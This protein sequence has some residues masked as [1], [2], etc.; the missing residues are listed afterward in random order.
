MKNAHA[1]MAFSICDDVGTHPK[2]SQR[3]E[4]THDVSH[5]SL[6]RMQFPSNYRP[7]QHDAAA[8]LG[9]SQ[10][11]GPYERSAAFQQRPERVCVTVDFQLC[12][13]RCEALADRRRERRGLHRRPDT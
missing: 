9:R 8:H 5:V 1:N 2:C 11:V 3:R 4:M 6:P 12:G 7:R 13:E 10:R